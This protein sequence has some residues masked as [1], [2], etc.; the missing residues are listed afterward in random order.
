[1]AYHL[2]I[3]LATGRLLPLSDAIN[4]SVTRVAAAIDQ[5]TA[6]PAI[7]VIVADN[8]THTIPDEGIGGFCGSADLI[9][10][11]LDPEHAHLD[12]SDRGAF[13]RTI[14]HETHHAL[15]WAG[16]GYGKTLGGA[17]VSEGLAGHFVH[18]VLGTRPE[19]WESAVPAA[20]LPKLEAEAIKA[21][22]DPNYDH[23]AWFFGT[24]DLAHWGGYS[25]GFSIV[26]R[27]LAAHPD[28]TPA[29]LS[30]ASADIF[31]P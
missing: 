20:E 21:W 19:A 30:G 23:A 6:L 26:G 15:R 31:R 16:V 1:M 28:Q 29:S 4:T 14:A 3:M 22:D 9:S 2:H 25:L 5:V 13:D 17:L 7:D 18:Q 27:Y 10:L 8:P 24:S 11:A 12:F